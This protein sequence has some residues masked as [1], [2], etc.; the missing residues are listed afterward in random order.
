MSEDALG[1]N[2]TSA[3]W[4]EFKADNPEYVT[5]VMRFVSDLRT[6]DGKNFTVNEPPV[7]AGRLHLEIGYIGGGAGNEDGDSDGNDEKS[8]PGPFKQEVEESWIC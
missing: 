7:K 4:D 8:A 6:K 2:K 3:I 5:E 1:R